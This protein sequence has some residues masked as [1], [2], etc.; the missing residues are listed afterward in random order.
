[1]TE[2]NKEKL[3][4][5]I[6][7]SVPGDYLAMRAVNQAAWEQAY[8]HIYTPEEMRGLF[9]D[10]LEQYGSWIDRR[11]ERIATLVAEVGGEIIGYCG[12]S[13]LHDGDG[14]IVTLYIHPDYQGQGVG[15]GLWHAA[16]DILREAGCKQVW[17]WVPAKAGAVEFY[18][19]KGCKRTE[20]GIYRV[21]DHEENTLGYTFDLMKE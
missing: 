8:N 14:E 12:A 5:T 18:E 19:Q 2:Q 16:L 6:R 21:G 7:R 9:E 13:L 20:E 1:M 10:E 17:V 11:L 4:Y 3:D 15:T